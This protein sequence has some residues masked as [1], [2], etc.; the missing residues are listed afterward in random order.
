V[1]LDAYFQSEKMQILMSS[2]GAEV[3][4]GERLLSGNI[5]FPASSYQKM[6]VFQI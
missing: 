2:L 1:I 5:E 3:V 4:G 6:S